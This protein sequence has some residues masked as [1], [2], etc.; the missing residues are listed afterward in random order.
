MIVVGAGD[1]AHTAATLEF[2]I[3]KF[4][5]LVSD[6]EQLQKNNFL[7]AFDLDRVPVLDH[8]LLSQRSVPCLVGLSTG[9]PELTGMNRFVRTSDLWLVSE[10]MTWART[11]SRW[12]RLGRPVEFA[13]VLS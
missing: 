7:P 2:H 8:W 10:D 5:R 4:G 9:H 11:L 6:L 13:G 3:E 12:Y 1:P